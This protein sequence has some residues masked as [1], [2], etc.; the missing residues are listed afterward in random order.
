MLIHY[1]EERDEFVAVA[2][3]TVDVLVS[4]LK[5]TTTWWVVEPRRFV[6]RYGSCGA[7]TALL[8]NVFIG[9]RLLSV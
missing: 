5:C 9:H 1:I 2:V 8:F 7:F 6:K 4:G 3:Y